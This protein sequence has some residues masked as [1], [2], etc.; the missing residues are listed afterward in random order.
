[1]SK[2]LK[3]FAQVLFYLFFNQEAVRQI[4]FAI[5][6]NIIQYLADLSVHLFNYFDFS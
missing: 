5:T 3:K 2:S 4:V 6:L 1:M